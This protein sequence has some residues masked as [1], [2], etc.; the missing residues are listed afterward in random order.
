MFRDHDVESARREAEKR[1]DICTPLGTIRT[2]YQLRAVFQSVTFV[3]VV[4]G[5][6]CVNLYNQYTSPEESLSQDFSTIRFLQDDG[7]QNETTPSMSP[8]NETF[9]P[10]EAPSCPEL[11]PISEPAWWCVWYS[12]GVLY[13]F[14]A[15]AI[16]CDEFFVPAL[17]EMSGPRRLNLSMDVAGAT[18]MAAGGSA[19]EL[20]TSLIG[21]FQESEIGFGTIVGSA[22][23]NVLFVIAMCSLLAKEVLT[24]TWWPLFRDS[25]YYAIGLAVLAVLVG[26]SSP[27]EVEWWEA[28]ILFLMYI[29]YILLM[30]KNAD[31]YKMLTGKVL[32]YPEED[33]DD[34]DDYE[35]RHNH[36]QQNKPANNHN[37]TSDS[38]EDR[39]RPEEPTSREMVQEQGIQRENSNNGSLASNISAS[40]IAHHQH[41]HH[42]PHFRWQGTFRAGILK[43]LK[44]PNS[45]T[46]T[47]G[48]G[49]VAKIAGDADYVFQQV[50]M[51]GNGHIDREELKQL[52]NLLECYVSPAE[53]EEVFNQL[54]EDKD[55]TVC[56]YTACGGVLSICFGILHRKLTCS[57]FSLI[58]TN[59]I[60]RGID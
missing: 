4:A 38:V 5:Y 56:A 27:D 48:V 10:S 60:T 39:T 30:W 40:H 24:L 47:A 49:I 36:N 31:L 29:G 52:F 16:V 21:T 46:D 18:L 7:G 50:D 45:W 25:L 17:E 59:S 8:S 55:G 13:M 23:F 1:L 19:P 3:C 20:F 34:D 44:D 12:I 11:D 37:N 32:E 6:V 54:D 22:V 33:D 53:L 58:Q 15:L 9:A 26:V 14:L 57:F 2:R 28:L 35:D 51:D 43:L 41:E 42:T